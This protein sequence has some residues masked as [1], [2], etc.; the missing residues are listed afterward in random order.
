MITYKQ[1]EEAIKIKEELE[2]IEKQIDDLE[3]V[4]HALV[5]SEDDRLD[6]RFTAHD[7]TGCGNCP[8]CTYNRLHGPALE[9]IL[10]NNLSVRILSMILDTKRLERLTLLN[11]L[12]ELNIETDSYTNK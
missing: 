6:A 8:S 12:N 11:N 3:K 1:F 5:T 9:F 2:L 7:E 4:L 10:D